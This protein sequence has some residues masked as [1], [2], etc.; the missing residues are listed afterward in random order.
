MKGTARG[1]GFA[2]N[3]VAIAHV[4]LFNIHLHMHSDTHVLRGFGGGPGMAW[5]S[6]GRDLRPPWQRSPLFVSHAEFRNPGQIQTAFRREVN[7][8]RLGAYEH[9]A[10]ATTGRAIIRR[11]VRPPVPSD[12][13]QGAPAAG[14]GRTPFEDRRHPPPTERFV[15]RE[16]P[17]DPQPAERKGPPLGERIVPRER[18]PESRPADRTRELNPER[19]ADRTPRERPPE[20]RLRLEE[21]RVVPTPKERILEPEPRVDRRRV[22][23]AQGESSPDLRRE[24]RPEASPTPRERRPEATPTPRERRPEVTPTPRER[25]DEVRPRV[26][27]EVRRPE[28]PA[29]QVEREA[30]PAPKADVVKEAPKERIKEHPREE[31]H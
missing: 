11:E 19:K 20:P 26:D 16:R 5:T 29:R 17:V 30:R 4:N 24:R 7:R 25:P 13:R 10:Q 15:P 9:H 3:V 23:P 28:T 8:E 2:W 6:G 1:G 12:P 31:R 14:P 18:T 27:R 21:R 22:E